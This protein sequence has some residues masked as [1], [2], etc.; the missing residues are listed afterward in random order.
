MSSFNKKLNNSNQF[1]IAIK[2]IKSPTIEEYKN[3]TAQKLITLTKSKRA[4]I[5]TGA[6][7]T[8]ISQEYADELQ[9]IPIG[10]LSITTA[11]NDCE[12]KRYKID[13]AIPVTAL[14][15]TEKDGKKNSEEIIIDEVHWAHSQHKIHSIPSIGRDRGYDI[16]LGMDILSK[17][18]ITMFN[19]QII[20]SF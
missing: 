2:V 12:V 8:C 14:R 7:H 3:G 9:L 11:S 5:D 17:M 18:H 19:K 16:I 13:F 20:M 6:T 1:I 10:K 4:L 15:T